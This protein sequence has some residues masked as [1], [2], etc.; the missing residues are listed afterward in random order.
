MLQIGVD[1]RGRFQYNGLDFN[2]FVVSV[3]ACRDVFLYG[4]VFTIEMFSYTIV[5]VTAMQRE[6]E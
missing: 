3:L 1:L 6:F 2:A 5:E 4:G